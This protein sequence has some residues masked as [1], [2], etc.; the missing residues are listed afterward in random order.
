MTPLTK[1]TVTGFVFAL[2]F[3]KR[4]KVWPQK[5]ENAENK[6]Q[7]KKQEVQEDLYRSTGM[8]TYDL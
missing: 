4:K 6:W 3:V 2:S 8:Y 7:K 5:D 1:L